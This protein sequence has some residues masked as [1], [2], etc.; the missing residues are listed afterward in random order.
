MMQILS[1]SWY[2]T[3]RHLRNTSRMPFVIF[4]NLIQPIIWLVLFSSLF[5][6]IIDIPGFNTDSYITFLAPGI[7]IM[8]TFMAGGYAGMSI[9]GDHTRGVLNRFLISPVKR[10]SMILGPL[11]QNAVTMIIQALIMI[12]LSLALG[13]SFAGGFGGILMLIAF[14]VLVGVA[15]G[16]LSMA[17]ALLVRNEQG[18][19]SAV[20]FV[21]LPLMFLSGLFMP[22]DLVPD[23]IHTVAL[24]NPVSWAGE[25]ACEVI[26]SHPD[27]S[28]IL[29]H[30]GYLLSFLIFAVWLATLAFRKYQKSV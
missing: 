26:G 2:M 25:A 23:W 12:L 28:L 3:L 15:F 27:W 13:A 10:S 7:I 11:A 30:F 19:M 9:I 21:S 8:S 29:S 1:H 20:S 14:G 24:F 16:A 17:L 5:S 18:L 22:L 6:N 4:M